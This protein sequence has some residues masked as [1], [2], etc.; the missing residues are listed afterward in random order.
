MGRD[1][2]VW[3]GA[4]G[5]RRFPVGSDPFD[6]SYC[7]EWIRHDRQQRCTAVKQFSLGESQFIAGV[8]APSRANLASPFLSERARVPDSALRF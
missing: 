8:A 4:V 1:G 2:A 5:L 6:F 3:C 7:C